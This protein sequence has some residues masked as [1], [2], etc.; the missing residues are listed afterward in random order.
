M[1]FDLISDLHLD[2]W[3]D[4][5]NINWDGLGT[6]LVAVVLGDISYDISRSYKTIVDISKHYKYVIFVDGNHEHNNQCGF[7]EHNQQLKNELSKYQNITFLNRNAIVIDGTAF[8]GANGWWTFDFMEPEISREEAYFYFLNN[9]HY[10]DPLLYEIF[11][12]ARED[13]HY[14]CE[15]VAKLTTDPGVAEI[16]VLTHTAPFNKFNDVKQPQHPAHFSRCGSSFLPKILDFDINSKIKNWCFGHVH[17]EYDEIIDGV[18]YVCH[19]RGRK[20][21]SPQNLFYYPKMILT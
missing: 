8:V 2:F 14:M 20:D 21:D 17:Q 12:T 18:R 19:P 15:V 11:H 10:S 4:N 9:G 5:E 16:V 6:S 7:Q 13:A 3:G 1:K